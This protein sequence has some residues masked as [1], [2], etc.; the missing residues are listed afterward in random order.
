LILNLERGEHCILTHA[1]LP[2]DP[3][4]TCQVTIAT[5]FPDMGVFLLAVSIFLARSGDQI[6]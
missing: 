4:Q 2:H 5:S 1:P 6:S 3:G